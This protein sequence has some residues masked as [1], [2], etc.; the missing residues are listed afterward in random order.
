MGT[1]HIKNVKGIT[2][3]MDRKWVVSFLFDNQCSAN[4]TRS[5][6]D[7]KAARDFFLSLPGRM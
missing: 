4:R 6:T 2:L 5:F 1:K 7:F 3:T